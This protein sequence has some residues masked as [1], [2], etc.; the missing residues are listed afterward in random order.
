MYKFSGTLLFLDLELIY[1]WAQRGT[2]IQKTI[3]ITHII[4]FYYKFTLSHFVPCE[5]IYNY[6][7]KGNASSG[8]FDCDEY[9]MS[10]LPLLQ[11]I[12]IKV[13]SKS[14]RGSWAGGPYR[15]IVVGLPASNRLG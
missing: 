12:L 14:L 15:L 10:Q 11:K 7:Y 2:H 9:S 8:L 13:F 6:F 3:F 4:I 1:L 5:Y